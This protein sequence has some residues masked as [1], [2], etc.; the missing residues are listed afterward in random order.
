MTARQKRIR[1]KL[2]LDP[3]YLKNRQRALKKHNQIAARI[4][5]DGQVWKDMPDEALGDIANDDEGGW[6]RLVEDKEGSIVKQPGGTY[7]DTKTKQSFKKVRKFEEMSA[8]PYADG[9]IPVMEV[10]GNE[11]EVYDYGDVAADSAD[12]ADADDEL[13]KKLPIRNRKE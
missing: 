8:S 5:E 2:D 3:R 11:N 12:S 13:A 6:F 7:Y 4:E 9:E 1:A 10:A